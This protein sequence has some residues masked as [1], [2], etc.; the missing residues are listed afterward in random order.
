MKLVFYDYY[1]YDYYDFG[2][3]GGRT[4]AKI[5]FGVILSILFFKLVFVWEVAFR[6]VKKLYWNLL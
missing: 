2:D 1:N 3:N 5:F 6:K 4:T